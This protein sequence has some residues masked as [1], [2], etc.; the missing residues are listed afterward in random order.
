M[1]QVIERETTGSTAIVT[2]NR[3]EKLNALSGDLRDAM[4]ETFASVQSD[5]AI[6]AVIVTGAGRGFCSGADLT[7]PAPKPPPPTQDA[8]LDDLGW[9]GRQAISVY[10]LNKPVIAAVNGVAAGAGMSLALACDVRVGS[11]LSRFKTV[12]IERNLS[13]DSGMSF[14]LPRIVGY[15]RAADLI[16]TSRMVDAEEAYRIGLLDRLVDADALLET[17]VEVAEQ[18]AAWPPLALRMSKRVLQHNI[19]CDL[20]DA[21]RFEYT[22]LTFGNKAVNDHKESIAAFRERRKPVYTGT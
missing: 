13:P 3:P 17:A 14:F 9:V 22:S 20:E 18:M 16:Y 5:D 2:L 19:E 8:L 21:L 1:T 12:F 6:R 11:E 7:T 15:S 10:R 4:L